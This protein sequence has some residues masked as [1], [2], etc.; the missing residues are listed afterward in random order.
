MTA[1]AGALVLNPP[2]ATPTKS[3]LSTPGSGSGCTAVTLTFGNAR[4]GEA[5]ST[6]SYLTSATG[7]GVCLY[8]N[9]RNN[10]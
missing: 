1:A 3:F 5:G 8:K 4:T 2:Q 7:H 9:G 10:N 6:T